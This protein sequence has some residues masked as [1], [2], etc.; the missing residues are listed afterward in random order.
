MATSLPCVLGIPRSPHSPDAQRSPDRSARRNA[1]ACI[2]NPSRS[3]TGLITICKRSQQGLPV[4]TDRIH[5][6]CKLFVRTFPRCV[7]SLLPCSPCCARLRR[8]TLSPRSGRSTCG[9]LTGSKY[10]F[11][12]NC[13]NFFS[14]KMAQYAHYGT[15]W[16]TIQTNGTLWHTMQHCFRVSTIMF[17]I[18]DKISNDVT[19][20]AAVQVFLN[21]YLSWWVLMMNR[22]SMQTLSG[23]SRS[24]PGNFQKP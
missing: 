17:L 6:L 11:A 18:R 21:F 1:W 13:T 23:W 15:L 8:W 7:R 9:S 14:M 3:V 12:R 20:Q 5:S 19:C 16:H 24:T 22:K 4:A 2:I 10:L